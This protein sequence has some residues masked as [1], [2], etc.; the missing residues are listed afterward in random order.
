[1]EETA[2]TLTHRFNCGRCLESTGREDEKGRL[3]GPPGAG[4]TPPGA[5]SVLNMGSH[6]WLLGR[7]TI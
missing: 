4:P 2:E 5:G 6:H 3:P 1:M 7:E